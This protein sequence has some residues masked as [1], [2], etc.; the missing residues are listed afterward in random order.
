[1]RTGGGCTA[2]RCPEQQ[3]GT[4]ESVPAPRCTS[5]SQVDDENVTHH[6]PPKKSRKDVF[7]GT[8]LKGVQRAP[9]ESQ[10]AWNPLVQGSLR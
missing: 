3:P 10:R 9:F 6:K 2:L 7:S 1:M 5:S 8:R 4:Q